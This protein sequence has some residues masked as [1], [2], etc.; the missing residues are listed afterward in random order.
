[1]SPFGVA[2]NTVEP[3]KHALTAS[4]VKVPAAGFSTV[5]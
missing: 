3:L 1:M 2:D 5:N 4:A